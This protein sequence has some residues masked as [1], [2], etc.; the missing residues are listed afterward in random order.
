MHKSYFCLKLFPT[1]AK[2]IKYANKFHALLKIIGKRFFVIVITEDYLYNTQVLRCLI[3]KSRENSLYN[4]V[5]M[6]AW[7]AQRWK[8]VKT[9]TNVTKEAQQGRFLVRVT[10]DGCLCVIRHVLHC[11][12]W[13]TK[14]QNGS[15]PTGKQSSF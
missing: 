6:I 2:F 1:R 15:C 5:C 4:N 10:T 12:N 13:R 3:W 7:H 11:Q 9:L 14:R 8:F